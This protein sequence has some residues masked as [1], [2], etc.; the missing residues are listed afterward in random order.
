MPLVRRKGVQMAS[1]KALEGHRELLR[2]K[3]VTGL[4]DSEI[5]RYVRS[6][7]KKLLLWS[8]VILAVLVLTAIIVWR[9]L[10]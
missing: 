2:Q 10:H 5:E 6:T 4:P 7:R 3:G 9:G 8:V 1:R